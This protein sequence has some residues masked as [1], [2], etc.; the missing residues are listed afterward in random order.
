MNN[1]V[2]SVKAEMLIPREGLN[3]PVTHRGEIILHEYPTTANIDRLKIYA[4]LDQ[5][6]GQEVSDKKLVR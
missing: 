3:T 2:N 1:R 4:G 5:T 6:E